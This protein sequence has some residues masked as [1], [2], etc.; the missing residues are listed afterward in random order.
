MPNRLISNIWSIGGGDLSFF[1]G[2]TLD[3][4]VAG[5]VR[6]E[7]LSLVFRYLPSLMIANAF[8]AFVFVAAAWPSTD[9]IASL[10]WASPL[11]VYSLFFGI[12]FR[13]KPI[14]PQT[15]STRSIRRVSRNAL[16]LGSLWGA[17]PIFFFIGASPVGQ[18]IITCLCTGLLAAGAIAFASLPIAA[19]AFMSPIFVASAIAIACSGEQAYALV[20]LLMVFY[21]CLLIRGVFFHTLQLV[22]RISDQSSAEEQAHTDSLTQLPNRASFQRGLNSALSYPKSTGEQIAVLYLDLDDFKSVN[23]ELG[24]AGGDELLTQVAERL[25]AHARTSDTLTRLSGDEFALLVRDI[26][27]AEEALALAER[28]LESFRVPFVIDGLDIYSSASIGIAMAPAAGASSEL[29]LKNADTALYRVKEDAGGS[30]QLFQP[31]HDAR[32]R[33][34]RAIERD[35]HLALARDEFFLVYQPILDLAQNRLSGCEA[36]LRWQ[37][38]LHGVMAPSEFIHIAEGTKLIHS[39]GEWVIRQASR[40]AS[41]WPVESKV[42]LNISAVQ[43]R[44]SGTIGIIANALARSGLNPSRLEIEI[45][46][47][48]ILS[49]SEFALSTLKALRGLGI[50]CALDDFG[51]GYASLSCLRKFPFDRVKIDQSFVH[52][53]LSDRGCASIVKSVIELAHDLK[54]S[55]TAEGV[56]RQEELA[57]LRSTTCDEVQGF[58]VSAPRSAADIAAMFAKSKGSGVR[59]A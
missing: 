23:D 30:V 33:E 20:G 14:T 21:A 11:I 25:K 19:I 10:V 59:A 36:L 50:K 26:R 9:R 24:H 55:V 49:D 47:S 13:R 52:D 58:L 18:L 12:R 34:R 56:E 45:T 35:L 16:L 1:G 51:T 6:A 4:P 38:P 41:T 46:E 28:V 15:V 8:N 57:Y 44:H 5:R 32:V 37:H 7:Q 48:A 29:L 42:A 54:I 31:D 39:I 3:E 2:P 43:L 53:M 17:L 22:S 27:N 40:S